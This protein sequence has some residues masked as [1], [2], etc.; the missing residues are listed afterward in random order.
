M[1]EDEIAGEDNGGPM[2]RRFFR[3]MLLSDS[4]TCS[5]FAPCSS[6]FRGDF[7]MVFAFS[8]SLLVPPSPPL[9]MASK[10]A[11]TAG[12]SS[13]AS[14]P[15]LFFSASKPFPFSAP[16]SFGSSFAVF[17]PSPPFFVLVVF[18]LLEDDM[19]SLPKAL[20][21]AENLSSPF[22]FF[23]DS[24]LPARPFLVVLE[25][26]FSLFGSSLVGS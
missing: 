16:S 18:S 12:E 4:F 21:A 14:L 6:G 26:S 17:L 2:C 11:A 15:S 7:R 20:I 8:G 23:S 1:G 19:F 3:A 22:N 9:L 24:I 25:T 5:D 13:L 10:M